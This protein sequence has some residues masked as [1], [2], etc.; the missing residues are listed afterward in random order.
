M[1]SLDRLIEN[2]DAADPEVA[3]QQRRAV[4]RMFDL[5]DTENCLWR[6]LASHFAEELDVCGGSCGNCTGQDIVAAA[7]STARAP[8]AGELRRVATEDAIRSHTPFSSD[9]DAPQDSELFERLRALRKRLADE[10]KV[11]AYVVFSD[12]TLQAMAVHKPRTAGRLLEIHGVGQKKLDEYGDAFLA[13]I[14][15]SGMDEFSQ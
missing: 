4:R 1:I 5:A 9:A 10:R 13:E 12:R 3:D 2:A 11:P 8:I 6:R 7:L 15:A 14:N